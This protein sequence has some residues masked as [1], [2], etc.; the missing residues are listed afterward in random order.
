M[1]FF[2][3]CSQ[4]AVK[5]GFRAKI[6]AYFSAYTIINIQSSTREVHLSNNKKHGKRET[7]ENVVFSGDWRPRRDSNARRPA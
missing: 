1:L 2:K 3:K 5:P 7:P 6:N 4:N